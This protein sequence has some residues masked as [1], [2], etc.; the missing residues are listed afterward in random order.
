MTHVLK[1]E[2][3][4][5]ALEYLESLYHEFTSEIELKTEDILKHQQSRIRP[6][7]GKADKVYL[8]EW[9]RKSFALHQRRTKLKDMK[10]C[11]DHQI[12]DVRTALDR[13]DRMAHVSKPAARDCFNILPP[14]ASHA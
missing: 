4:Q 6:P 13:L 1:K 8:Q 9:R 7:Q 2:S 10:D 3:L 12:Q 14:V 5:S 11:L